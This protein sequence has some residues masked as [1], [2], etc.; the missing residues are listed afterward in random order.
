MS[1]FFSTH[2]VIGSSLLF[3]HDK[4]KA[5]VWLIDFAKTLLLPEKVFI[6]HKSEWVS[7]IIIMIIVIFSTSIYVAAKSWAVQI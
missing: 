4:T 2:E 5:N 7:T 1:I 3:V 6:D